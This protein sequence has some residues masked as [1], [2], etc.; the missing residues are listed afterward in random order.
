MVKLVLFHI[1]MLLYMH[2]PRPKP[3]K[4]ELKGKHKDELPYSIYRAQDI[5]DSFFVSGHLVH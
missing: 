5:P 2:L 3:G 4:I 1:P